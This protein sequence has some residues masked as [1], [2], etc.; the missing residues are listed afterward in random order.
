MTEREFELR[1]ER[2]FDASAEEV[3]DAWTSEEVLK[4]WFHSGPDWDTPTA[5]LDL[6][7]GGKVRVAMREPDGTEHAMGGEYTLIERPHRL[8]LTW[9]FDDWPEKQQMIDLEFIE[10]GGRTTVVMVN[11]GI[12][13]AK[14]RADQ[15]VG[16][17]GCFD[18]LDRTLATRSS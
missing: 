15:Q 11:S 4:R 2:T 16:W 5:E 10:R 6:R 9:T 17:D 1:I 13:T 7:V 18:S 8:S 14:Q 3:F 12:A